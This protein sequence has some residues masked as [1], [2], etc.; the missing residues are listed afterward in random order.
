MST[1]LSIRRW[2]RTDRPQS[3]YKGALNLWEAP[4]YVS[5]GDAELASQ[6]SPDAKRDRTFI[7]Q[8]VPQPAWIFS[9][10]SAAPTP[11]VLWPGILSSSSLSYRT[12]GRQSIDVR[13]MEPFPQFGLPIPDATA[14]QQLPAIQEAASLSFRTPDR[15][16]LLDLFRSEWSPEF[17]WIIAPNTSA[18]STA[19]LWPAI[20]ENSGLNYRSPDRA[21]LDVRTQRWEPDCG[22]VQKTVDAIVSTWIP[23]FDAETSYRTAERAKLDVRGYEWNPENGWIFQAI[24]I[25]STVAQQWPA[26]LFGSGLSFRSS[27]RAKLDLITAEWRAQPG[28]LTPVVDATVAKWAPSWS[29]ERK[30]DRT[31]ERGVLDVRQSD[32]WSPEIG[33]LVPNIP[34]PPPGPFT[35]A[36]SAQITWNAE[37]NALVSYNAEVSSLVTYAAPLAVVTWNAETGT[38]I[39]WNAEVSTVTTWTES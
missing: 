33:W 35:P 29:S 16:S 37:V 9:S 28:W 32:T 25:P 13:Y 31:R 11:A 20:L 34:P 21:T 1:F 14:D 15:R 18:A 3:V 38:V 6:R 8:D 17:G 5:I 7:L 26:V 24:P 22:W 4:L 39:S 23:V 12:N 36:T 19:Q 10:L 2:E 27:E 30:G